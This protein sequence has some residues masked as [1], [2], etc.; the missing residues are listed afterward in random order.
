VDADVLEIAPGYGRWTEFLAKSARRV[1]PVD[2]NENCLSACQKRFEHPTHI[3]YHLCDGE[4]LPVPDASLDFIWTFD[5]FVH[6]DPPVVRAYPRE[7]G[8]VLRPGGCAVV[9]HADKRSWSLADTH[10]GSPGD[11]GLPQ[12]ASQGRLRDDGN[13]SN[14]TGRMVA[15][16][17]QAAGMVVA[18]TRSSGAENQYDVA[19]DRDVISGLRKPPS[20]SDTPFAG[21][22][23]RTV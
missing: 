7:I 11:P 20:P 9:H 17:A 23:K 5:S 3:K 22:P 13:R 4:S 18:Q 1:V 6:M 12:L 16:W 10:D 21:N 2:V 19:K 8:R 14:V 15:D